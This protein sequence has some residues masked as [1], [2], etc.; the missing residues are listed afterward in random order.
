M[1][2]SAAPRR[3]AITGVPVAIASTAVKPNGS[4]ESWKPQLFAMRNI[5]FDGKRWS[6]ETATIGGV[7]YKFDGKFIKIKRYPD[8]TM[9]NQDVL[10]GRLI[11]FV[12]GRQTLSLHA[13]YRSDALMALLFTFAANG[14]AIVPSY[15]ASVCF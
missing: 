15:T 9:D 6:F 1:I 4:V 13:W 8:G 7:S 10:K 14:I 11:K 3:K 2:S 5:F 12:G